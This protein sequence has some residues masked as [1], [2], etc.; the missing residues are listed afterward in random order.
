MYSL[1]FVIVKAWLW[2]RLSFDFVHGY[3][4]TVSNGQMLGVVMVI[5]WHWLGLCVW[6]VCGC[7][8]ALVSVLSLCLLIVIVGMCLSL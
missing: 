5:V 4:L 2:P 3:S 8:L 6:F 7:C 1:V